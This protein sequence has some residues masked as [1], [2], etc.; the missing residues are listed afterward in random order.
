M[1][2]ARMMWASSRHDCDEVCVAWTDGAAW[3]VQPG[4]MAWTWYSQDRRWWR[5]VGT[6]HVCWSVAWKPAGRGMARQ[7]HGGMEATWMVEAQ[8]GWGARRLQGLTWMTQDV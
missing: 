6:V 7:G 8:H 2:R 1:A 5:L 3:K 4:Q